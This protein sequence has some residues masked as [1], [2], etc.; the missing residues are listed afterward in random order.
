MRFM[1]IIE[2]VSSSNRHYILLA[3]HANKYILLGKQ[4]LMCISIF[5]T[6]AVEEH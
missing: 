2:D 1:R 5:Q 6:T 3:F 4:V